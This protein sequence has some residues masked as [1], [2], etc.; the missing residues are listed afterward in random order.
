[1]Y[2]GRQGFKRKRKYSSK[3]KTSKGFW[4]Y[5]GKRPRYGSGGYAAGFSQK[6]SGQKPTIHRIRGQGGAFPDR[7]QVKLRYCDTYTATSTL[8]ALVLQVMRGN[9]LFDPD[10]TGSGHQ[11]FGFD[12]WKTI[13]SY[14]RVLA[15]SIRVSC[16]AQTSTSG[17]TESFRIIVAPRLD[18]SALVVNSA[19]ELPY[20]QTALGQL[21]KPVY[22]Q[23]YMT[24]AKVWGVNPSSVTSED[25]YAAL[26]TA[27]PVAQWYWHVYFQTADAATTGAFLVDIEM[28]YYAQF[29]A[30]FV[31]SGS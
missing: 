17:A 5:G 18:T 10:S 1:M 2:G 26:I 4:Q 15:S 20:A 27:N 24:T 7:L 13:M 30:P 22:M 28:C 9:S 11:P 6:F 3:G 16:I 21:F 14:Y 23:Q 29:E 8:G 25:D 19:S 12:Q 31:S